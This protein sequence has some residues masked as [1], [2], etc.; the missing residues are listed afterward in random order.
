[1]DFIQKI[2]QYYHTESRHGFTGA[3]L[4]VFLL[5]AGLVLWRFAKPLSLLKG[6]SLPFLVIGLVM[7]IGGFGDGYVTRKAL[8]QKLRLYQENKQAFFKEEVSK[9]ERTHHSWLRI[10]IVWSVLTLA[11]VLLLF[12]VKKSYW[13]GV[14]LGTLLMGITGNA[15]E[16]ISMRFNER[17]YREV[18][19]AAK[20]QMITQIQETESRIL[21]PVTV[22]RLRS[23]NVAI[24]A[25][26]ND[27]PTAARDTLPPLPSPLFL[28]TITIS[29]SFEKPAAVLA[30]NKITD[31]AN[32]PDEIE[33][34]KPVKKKKLLDYYHSDLIRENNVSAKHCWFGKK[35][36]D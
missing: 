33:I 15:E 30:I 8:P 32:E 25:I 36:L 34:I 18:L 2:L 9:V 6:L 4:G 5:I 19:Q 11:G 17:Y 20:P 31:Q 35:Y 28:D 26:Q 1:M 14:G 16:A 24:E 29:R 21:I 7:G 23:K 12:T 10:R 3:A 22:Q 13:L 27:Q